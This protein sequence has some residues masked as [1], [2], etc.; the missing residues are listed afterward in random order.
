M[1]KKKL[2]TP[3]QTAGEKKKKNKQVFHNFMDDLIKETYVE[4]R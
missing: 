1:A 3:A 4:T 2:N